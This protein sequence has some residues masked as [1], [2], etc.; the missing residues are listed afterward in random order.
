MRLLLDTNLLIDYF[1]QRE[2]FFQ[3]WK[4]LRCAAW[5]DDIELWVSAKSFTDVFYVVSKACSSTEIQAAFLESLSFLH[6]CSIE[7]EDIAA[8]AKE[9]WPD[10]EDC[11]IYIAARKIGAE[12]IL[13]RDIEGFIRSKIPGIAPAAFF[14]WLLDAKH[15]AYDDFDISG[16]TWHVQMEQTNLSDCLDNAQPNCP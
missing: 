16:E 10:F 9:A 15:V 7:S 12:F 3:A 11:L 1:S 2:P 5:F 6:V 14:S 4:T 8:A 13:T